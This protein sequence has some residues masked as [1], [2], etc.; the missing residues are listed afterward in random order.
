MVDSVLIVSLV[1][2]FSSVAIITPTVLH[3]GVFKYTGHVLGHETEVAVIRCDDSNPCPIFLKVC[4]YD[5]ETFGFCEKCPEPDEGCYGTG[6]ETY[7]GT[8]ACCEV[9]GCD[10]KMKIDEDL[11]QCCG[12]AFGRLP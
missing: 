9:C 8:K 3:S 7:N 4:N 10:E 11:G 12:T 5:S 6:Y 1:V 2:I